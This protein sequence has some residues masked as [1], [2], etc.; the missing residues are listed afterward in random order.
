MK[1]TQTRMTRQR[2]IILEELSKVTS[3]PT[4]DEVYHMVR[5]RL[6]H[7]SLGT[8]YRNL[9]LLAENKEIIKIESAGSVR[10]FDACTEPHSHIRCLTCGKVADMHGVS[11]INDM[12]SLEPAPG[13]S[14][15]SVRME[16]DGYCKDCA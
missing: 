3:H 8:V 11:V 2:R 15:V 13:F 6:A 9:E 14:V 10:R 7:I 4:A 16:F 12:P 1:T 5:K